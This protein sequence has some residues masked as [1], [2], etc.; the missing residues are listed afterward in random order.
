[1]TGVRRAFRGR[2]IAAAL[3]RT[4][5]A[6]AKQAGLREA[7]DRER[8]AQRA[9]PRASTSATATCCEPG[10]V[11]AARGAVRAGLS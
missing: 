2:G 8:G 3:K 4:Q 5:I 7:A 10:L 9:D 6:W 11:I 1:M